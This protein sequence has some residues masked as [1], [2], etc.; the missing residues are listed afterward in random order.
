VRAWWKG[1]EARILHF[2][3][4]GRWKHSGYRALFARVPDPLVEKGDGNAFSAFL[5]ALRS[6][7]GRVGQAALPPFPLSLL[8]SLIRANGCIRVLEAGTGSGVSTACLA[9]AVAHREGGRVVTFDRDPADP[10]NAELWAGLPEAMRAAIEPR[11]LGSL[12]GMA[13][14]LEAGENYQAALLNSSRGTEHLLREFRLARQLVCPGGLILFLD[15]HPSEGAVDEAVE[16]IQAEGYSV[17]RL[18]AAGLAVSENRRFG[19]E[20][21]SDQGA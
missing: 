20:A 16:T 2:N 18:R 9:T 15:P 17:T 5:T 14:S 10:R 1:R 11:A 19:G 6:W 12:E 3:G 21:W 7:T 8:H 13:A 4:L